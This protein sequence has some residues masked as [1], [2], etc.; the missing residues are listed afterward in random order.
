MKFDD[1]QRKELCIKYVQRKAY[2]I[3]SYEIYFDL[4]LKH[5]VTQFRVKIYNQLA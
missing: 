1:E 4:T 3:E 5:I 2:L